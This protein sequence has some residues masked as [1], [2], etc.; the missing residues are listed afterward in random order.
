MAVRPVAVARHASD[1]LKVAAER[2]GISI[3]ED[4]E[5]WTEWGITVTPFVV[6]V[7]EQSRVVGKGIHH[8]LSAIVT[9]TGVF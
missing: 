7:D 6:R 8:D 3:I 9:S 5:I 1:Q 2:I 4:D